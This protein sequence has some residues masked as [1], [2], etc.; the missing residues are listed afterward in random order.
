V[1]PI[2]HGENEEL[3]LYTMQL[4][5]AE[6]VTTL[7]ELMPGK[8]R[9][10][11]ESIYT[12]RF[13]V[14]RSNV[15]NTYSMRLVDFAFEPPLVHALLLPV[16]HTPYDA[17][18]TP[19]GSAVIVIGS[20]SEQGRMLLWR[21]PI[22]GD[23]LGAA[24]LLTPN[25]PPTFSPHL[26]LS[27]VSRHYSAD[28]GSMIVAS[29]VSQPEFTGA[30][31]YLID[32]IDSSESPLLLS[33]LG[34][35]QAGP[36]SPHQ[37]HLTPDGGAATYVVD[38]NYARQGWWTDIDGDTNPISQLAPDAFSRLDWADDDRRALAAGSQDSQGQLFV[39]DFGEDGL[40][41][42]AVD[43][44]GMNPSLFHSWMDGAG[45]WLVIGEKV[46]GGSSIY[47]VDIRGAEPSP[48]VAIVGE[49]MGEPKTYAHRN[50]A[51]DSGRLFLA[52]QSTD[53][54]NDHFFV[55]I[56]DG[57]VVGRWA[58]GTTNQYM[59]PVAY[60]AGDAFVALPSGEQTIFLRVDTTN[61]D[62]LAEQVAIGGSF[63]WSSTSF[64]MLPTPD[65]AWLLINS[66]MEY[67]IVDLDQLIQSPLAIDGFT[68]TH[69]ATLMLP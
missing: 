61:P 41:Q 54:G 7:A 44:D 37:L 45:D 36:D 67:S 26:T 34:A 69:M 59:L 51:L 24:E 31:V 13:L 50:Q 66:N 18:L 1:L 4:G 39:L 58:L 19:D 48:P 33:D 27:E 2:Q 8:W 55:R 11:H 52:Q 22:V 28:G 62:A 29:S 64:H 56:E 42:T 3:A 9:R 5:V 46:A 35:F 60:A 16:G 53:Q 40:V 15:L 25:A 63:Q 12:D 17:E 38:Y 14:V 32:L 6:P 65:A 10:M 57:A 21:L 23:Q 43:L 30:Q 20:D 68:P 47:V 49:A